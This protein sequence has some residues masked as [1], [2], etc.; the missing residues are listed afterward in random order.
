MASI[1]KSS[2]S[3]YQLAMCRLVQETT[4]HDSG[5]ILDY[6][7]LGLGCLVAKPQFGFPEA[8]SKSNCFLVASGDVLTKPHLQ[9]VDSKMKGKKKDKPSVKIVAEFLAMDGTDKYERFSLVEFYDSV[10]RDICESSGILYIALT[11]LDRFNPF[12]RTPLK[13]RPKLQVFDFSEKSFSIREL[14][15]TEQLRCHVFCGDTTK[16]EDKISCAVMSTRIY[17]LFAENASES[18]EGYTYFLTNGAKERYY[19]EDELK[20]EEKKCPG[21]IIL[22]GDCRFVGVLN[23][24]DSHLEPVTVGSKS[25][26]GICNLYLHVLRNIYSFSG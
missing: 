5:Q 11:K 17:D 26:T 18:S 20:K 23:F 24:R 8:A 14:L 4:E 12:K 9:A 22:N 2:Q 1:V 19:T 21:G 13:R 16:K 25:E 6:F 15:D 7:I 10:D 3:D